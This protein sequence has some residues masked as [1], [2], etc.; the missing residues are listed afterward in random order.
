M[1]QKTLETVFEDGISMGYEAFS[2]G[3]NMEFPWDTTWF[4]RWNFHGIWGIFQFDTRVPNPEKLSEQ[5]LEQSW[6]HCSYQPLSFTRPGKCPLDSHMVAFDWPWNSDMF[7]QSHGYLC[8]V[9][10][11]HLLEVVL[12]ILR[13]GSSH[14]NL[15]NSSLALI[16][17]MTTLANF[18]PQ[19]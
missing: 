8:W 13:L 4:W 18:W 2:M 11:F 1:F 6:M 14:T 5:L 9:Y 15:I 16:F 7:G 17:Y 3:Y 10:L 19:F 12:N